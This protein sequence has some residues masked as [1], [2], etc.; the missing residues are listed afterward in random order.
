M[1][2]NQI[3]TENVFL[4]KN[5]IYNLISFRLKKKI[6]KYTV[7]KPIILCVIVALAA[8]LISLSTVIQLVLHS[9]Y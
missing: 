4:D 3:E 6:I 5:T 7:Y 1:I 9:F 2:H 8:L